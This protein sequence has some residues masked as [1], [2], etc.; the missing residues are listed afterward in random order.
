MNCA[1]IA[2]T[3]TVIMSQALG[4]RVEVPADS[5]IIPSCLVTLIDEVEVPA[6][7]QGVLKELFV[8]E[9]DQVPENHL[10]GQIDDKQ[11]VVLKEVSEYKLAVAEEEADN[12]INV[13]YAKAAAEVSRNEYEQSLEA[14]RIQPGTIPHLE[15]MR[16]WLQLKQYTLQIEQAQ[17]ELAI[18]A[19]TVDVRKAELRAADE[20]VAR[21]KIF[22]PL[23]G[24][25]EEIY[26]R[27]G[28]WLRPGEPVMKLLRM[29]NLW[30]EGF[31]NAT[32][33]TASDVRDKPVTVTVMLPGRR[34]EEFTGKIVHASSKIKEGALFLVKAEVENRM[35]GNAWLLRSGMNAEMRI[36][37][38]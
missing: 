30:V 24:V 18:A 14:N 29:N 19:V 22:A 16:L 28:E 20:D 10:L 5:V 17:H 25:V 7:E 37:L 31:V 35:D 12:Q 23:D 27:K 8:K 6:Q 4:S 2:L 32:Y 21:R 34:V 36:D 26:F 33:Y 13:E 11:S 3:S 15:V 38:K 1:L 9:G